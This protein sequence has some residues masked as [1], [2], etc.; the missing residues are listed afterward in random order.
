MKRIIILINSVLILSCGVSHVKIQELSE[1]KSSLKKGNIDAAKSKLEQ[2]ENKV[3][4]YFN[5]LNQ[6]SPIDVTK[7]IDDNDISTLYKLQGDYFRSKKDLEKS[8]TYYKKSMNHEKS[9]IYEAVDTTKGTVYFSSKEKMD[10][11]IAT[12]NYKNAKSYKLEDKNTKKIIEIMDRF[13]IEANDEGSQYYQKEE[14]NKARNNFIIAYEASQI[15]G[16]IDTSYLYNAALCSYRMENKSKAIKDYTKLVDLGYTG[17]KM[18]YMLFDKI[19][20]K[21]VAFANEKEI[22][23]RRDMDKSNKLYGRDSIFKSIS[24]RPNLIKVLSSMLIKKQEYD[25]ALNLLKKANIE[26]P[27]DKDFLLQQGNI[28]LKKGDEKGFLE[29]MLEAIKLNPNNP[30]LYFNVGVISYN[31]YNEKIKA[32]VPLKDKIKDLNKKIKKLGKRRKNRAKKKELQINLKEVKAELATLKEESNEKKTE[33]LKY[34]KKAIELK[35]DYSDAYVNLVI[36]ILNE[37]KTINSEMSNL[38]FSKKDKK[39]YDELKKKKEKVYNSAKFYLEK[40]VEYDPKN[41]QLLETL[42]NIYSAL[43]M[44]KKYKTIKNQIE[45]L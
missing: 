10:K 2:A 23:N 4:I 22:K 12:G 43:G 34:Y 25:K 28:Y 19:Q 20:N 24:V 36:L 18:N 7:K 5:N 14:Y 21:M 41:K 11:A 40:A 9:T 33:A 1:V 45:N 15:V 37:E 38:G 32:L 17:I 26:Y 27:S 3:D 44:T 31:L 29:N 13:R 42:K 35:N 30:Q 8:I 39:R 6:N 16:Q